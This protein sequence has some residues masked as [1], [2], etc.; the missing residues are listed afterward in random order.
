MR[1]ADTAWRDVA[2]FYSRIFHAPDLLGL[3]I[4]LSTYCAHRLLNEVPVWMFIIGGS[5]TGKTSQIVEPMSNLPLI[6]KMGVV[7]DKTF[8]NAYDVRDNKPKE[9]GEGNKVEKVGGQGLLFDLKGKAPLN[10]VITWK[11]FSTFSGLEDKDK[12]KL[13]SQMRD[14]FDGE[15]SHRLGNNREIS[16][17]GKVSMI[18]ATTPD[19][20][21]KAWGL[22]SELGDRFLVYRMEELNKKIAALAMIDKVQKNMGKMGGIR[23]RQK[24]LI[25]DLVEGEDLV[26]AGLEFGNGKLPIGDLCMLLCKMRQSVTWDRMG[27]GIVDIGVEEM[28]G[29]IVN[30]AFQLARGSAMLSRRVKMNMEDLSITVRVLLDTMPEDRWKIVRMIYASEKVEKEVTDT[31]LVMSLKNE[32]AKGRIRIL[33]DELEAIGVV[34]P[35]RVQANFGKRKYRRITLGETVKEWLDEAFKIPRLYETF[36]KK[37]EES[38]TDI[39]RGKKWIT[40]DHY[41]HSDWE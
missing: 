11:D 10:G 6:S 26:K 37:Y 12:R 35:T 21:K 29:R 9:D 38:E 14:I 2:E 13:Q 40:H 31:G 27:R 7:N 18:A 39:K 34:E 20:F 33:L 4:A 41:S 15:L 16:W 8:I 25:W 19:D 17:K 22:Q 23:D 24:T 32:M 30:Q 28:P 36:I 1:K 3:R 5:S